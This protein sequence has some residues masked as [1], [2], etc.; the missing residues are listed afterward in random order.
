MD[1]DT[2]ENKLNIGIAQ[3]LLGMTRPWDELKA[4]LTA[5][6]KYNIEQTH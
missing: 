5:R 4:E 6:I 2:F 3:S 1:K